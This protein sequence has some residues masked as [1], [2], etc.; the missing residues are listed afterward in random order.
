MDLAHHERDAGAQARL[1]L[2]IPVVKGW[3][4]ELGEEVASLGVQVHG[5]MGYIEETGAAQFLRDVRISSIYEGTNGIQAQDLVARKLGGDGGAAMAALLAEVE[6]VLDAGDKVADVSVL[7]GALRPA[8]ADLHATT[9]TILEQLKDNRDAALAGAFDYMMQVGYVMGGWHL[10]RSGL[11]AAAKMSAGSDNIFYAR[12]LATGR[13]Y[14]E[15]LLPRA[16][17]SGQVVLNGS[18]ALAD[19]AEDWL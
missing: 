14:A 18:A 3:L 15:N 13:F 11:V 5:G 17:A 8:L 19:Y 16:S 4:T 10:L 7:C 9:A 1:D 6:L 2:M 12:K